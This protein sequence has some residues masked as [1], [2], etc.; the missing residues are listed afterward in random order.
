MNTRQIRVKIVSLRAHGSETRVDTLFGKRRK[1]SSFVW[2]ASV[3][4]GLLN[5]VAI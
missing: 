4:D 2:R 1:L 5:F 3:I